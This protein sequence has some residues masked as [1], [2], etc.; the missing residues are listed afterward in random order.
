MNICLYLLTK[1]YYMWRNKQKA[2]R[3]DAMTEEQKVEYLA[4]TKDRGNKRLDFRFQ[5]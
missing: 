4:N 1:W 2:R 5:H 3:W